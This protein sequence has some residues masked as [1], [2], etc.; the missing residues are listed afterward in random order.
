MKQIVIWILVLVVVLGAATWYITSTHKDTNQR[1]SNPSELFTFSGDAISFTIQYT[2]DG[3]HAQ[4]QYLGTP[5]E[6]T[7]AVSASGARYES[8]DGSIVFWEHQ[9]TASLEIAG[10]T[11][12][13]EATLITFCDEAGNR[14]SS[15]AKARA[16][17]LSDAQFG[18]TY[19]PEYTA[20]MSAKNLLGSWQ[21]QETQY[22]TN[23]TIRPADSAR[24]VLTFLPTGRFSATTDCNSVTG[25]YTVTE[26]TLHL[27]NLTATEMACPDIQSQEKSFSGMLAAVEE[28]VFTPSGDLA[29]SFDSARMIFSQ[30]QDNERVD[31]ITQDVPT[32][33]SS[34]QSETFSG[35][36]TAVS[37][38]CFS[39]GI[40]SATIDG[41]V[42][43]LAQGWK[44]GAVGEVRF[45]DGIGGL[46]SSI[47]S[48]VHAF[49]QKTSTG[50][51]LYGSND[52][53]IE[54]EIKN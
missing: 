51:T 1:G 23:K 54:P 33:S 20:A 2:D 29:L 6:L 45:V 7:R 39:D 16:A 47:G 5:Y 24:F 22:N 27:D 14:Y 8:S 49:A 19:C 10:A 12:I 35:T 46:E 44:Q 11:I 15:E 9:G 36:L 43:I 40:C 32:A 4:L 17:G 18:A 21:W 37:T 52:Y 48:N 26:N 53:Y 38:A 34:A 3:E 50:Y 13:Q 41:K 30:K 25:E 28:Y 31:P 42:L